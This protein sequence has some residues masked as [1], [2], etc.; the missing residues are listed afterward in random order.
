M[1]EAPR[2]GQ[3]VDHHF[4]WVEEQAAGRMEGRKSRPCLIVA[5]EPQQRAPPRVTVL[6]ITSRPPRRGGGAVAIPDDVQTRI[7]L[8]PARPAWVVIGEANMFTWPGFDLVPQPHGGF[9][10]GEITRGF[11]ERVRDAVLRGRPRTVDRD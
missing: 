4:L 2:V 3:I 9:V 7:G 10:R 6:P 11:F 1:R 5:V 8:D